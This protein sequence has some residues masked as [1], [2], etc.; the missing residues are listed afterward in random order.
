LKVLVDSCVWSLA[1]RRKSA[2]SGMN[3]HETR[4]VSALAEG[5]K[6]GRVAI[7]GPVRQEV[8]SGIKHVQQFEKLHEHLQAFQDA[9]HR[10]VGL[11]SG[12][13]PG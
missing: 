6:D 5:I 13:S 1:L 11:C 3:S 10:I 7:V 9:P 8:L 4:L 2:T 12:S